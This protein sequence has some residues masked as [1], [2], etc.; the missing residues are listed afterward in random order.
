MQGS[1]S[2]QDFSEGLVSLNHGMDD[3][4]G[5]SL[6]QRLSLCEHAGMIWSRARVLVAKAAGGL[7][8]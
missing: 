2:V 8:W 5:F 1:V 3:L 4:E 6:H 7:L